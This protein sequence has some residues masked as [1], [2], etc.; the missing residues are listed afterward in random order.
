LGFDLIARKKKIESPLVEKKK[1]KSV[2]F[3]LGF[4]AFADQFESLLV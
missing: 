3:Y 4:R 1:K 2:L